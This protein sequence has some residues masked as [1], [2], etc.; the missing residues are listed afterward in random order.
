[1]KSPDYEMPGDDDGDNMY[2]VTVRATDSDGRTGT[3]DVTVKVKNVEEPGSVTLSPTQHRVGVEITAKLDDKDGGV[4][5]LMWQW[6]DGT[7]DAENPATNA[8]ADET[9]DTYTPKVEDIG[10]TLTAVATYRDA[11]GGDTDDTAMLAGSAAVMRDTRNKAP[12]FK[13]SKGNVITMDMRSVAET[14][15][16][17]MADDTAADDTADNVGATIIVQD[18]NVGMDAED[19]SLAFS[20]SGADESKF[21]LRA[22]VP[23]TDDATMLNVQVEVKG[24]PKF[25]YETDKTH[26]VTLTATDDYGQTAELQL[27]INITDVNEKPTIM[28]GGLAISGPPMRSYAENGEGHVADYKVTGAN[29]ASATWTLEG[30]DAMY[31]RLNPERGA[32]SQLMF[33]MP[34]NYEMPRGMAM[35]DTNTYMVTLKARDGTYMDTQDVTVMVTNLEED[36]EVALSPANPSI[37]ATTTATLTDPDGDVS[38]KSWQWSKSMEID[39]T[40]ENIDGATM[41]AYTPMEDDNGYYLKATVMYTDAHGSGKNAME[42]TTGKVTAG[43]PLIARYDT[44]NSDKIERNEAVQAIRDYR[45]GKLT[46][47]HTL[48]V[49]LAH[50]GRY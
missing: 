11:A 7:Y 49:V 48:T 38:G 44:D 17:N 26:M 21:R 23:D 22:A 47:E 25:N 40:Y 33:K 43:D 41:M 4:Y 15:M 36:G 34:P 16:G 32:M 50:L 20:L 27:T 18:P 45:A 9:S 12:M 2:K 37:G 5:G 10:S 31:F 8:I 19:D 13:D 39:G 14:A 3:K 46:R 6:Y 29:A 28:R 24:D 1:M 42:K 30:A 35:S